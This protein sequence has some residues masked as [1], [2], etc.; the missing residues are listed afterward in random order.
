MFNQKIYAAKR[1]LLTGL[2]VGACVIVLRLFGLLQTWELA[3]FD[4]SFRLRPL[5]PIDDRIIIVGIE[6]EDL[7]QVG[8]FPI[9][10]RT[11]AQ[12]L[13]KIQSYQPRTIGLDIY[14][15]LPVEPGH[16]E[17]LK[18]YRTLPNLIGIEQIKDKISP[19]VPPPPVL[20][21]TKQVGFNN[22]LTDPD[23]R[24]RR[25]LLYWWT[26]NDRRHQSFALTLALAYL[27]T[28]G[29]TPEAAPDDAGLQLGKAVFSRLRS[30]DGAYIHLDDGG[31]QFLA[32][33][34]GAAERLPRVSMTEV[35][36]GR[37]PAERFR[38]RIVLIGSTAVSLKDFVYTS[39]SD[40]TL[41]G[42][43]PQQMAG[44]E[45]QANF[46]SQIISAAVDGRSQI[47]FWSKPLEWLW[48]LIWAW[49]G[50]YL[51]WKVRS[52]LKAGLALLLTK[53]MLVLICYV[54]FLT[55]WW[56][57]LVPSLIAVSAS[58]IAIM[59]HM[60]HLQEELKRSKEF[61]NKIIN[62]IPDPIFVKDKQHRW[63][64]LN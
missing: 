51:S 42:S 2:G 21:A 45:L 30:G 10:D 53:V 32:N 1:V 14:R 4:Q 13:K 52:P 61:L 16:S 8:T 44:V 58:A 47:Q 33:L 36:A 18:T 23:G 64:V 34:R 7:R 20:E 54:A 9:P 40:G 63:I 6:E 29:I 28:N 62:T 37:V 60:A 50:A 11:M 39:Y 35:L 12:L 57:P 27:K 46:V 24:V 3:S 15:N 49:A 31:Y 38:D 41:D 22:H 55:N 25:G 19:G 56:L 59:A 5:E 26:D 48:I 17:L 43:A